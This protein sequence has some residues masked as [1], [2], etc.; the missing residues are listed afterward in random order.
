[1]PLFLPSVPLSGGTISGTL[2]ISGGSVTESTPVLDLSQTWNLAGTTFTG[3]KFNVTDSASASASLLCD[4][5]VGGVSKASIRKDGLIKAAFLEASGVYFGTLADTILVRGAAG[6]LDLRNLANAQT[7]QV[8]GTADAGLLNYR[9]IRTT[10]TTGGAATIA[11]E[12]LGTGVSGNTL[13]FTVNAVNALSLNASGSATFAA[14]VLAG[15][16]GALGWSSGSYFAAPS[17]GIIRLTQN[18]GS[19]FN[20]LNYGG[21]TASFPSQKRSGTILQ[22]RLADDSDFCTIQGKLRTDNAY[23]AGAPGAATGTVTITDSTGTAYRI[24]V[25]V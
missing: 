13:V 7:L 10:M 15:T 12:G 4:W 25:L 8:Y 11:A 1:M 18:S 19:G 22:G 6:T 20:R 3:L 17:D 5:Q 9:R 14:T 21:D 23:A 2:S 24:P 16:G